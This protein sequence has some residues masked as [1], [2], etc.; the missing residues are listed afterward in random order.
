MKNP[1]SAAIAAAQESCLPLRGAAGFDN[2]PPSEIESLN[3]ANVPA[4][5]HAFSPAASKV[6]AAR[7]NNTFGLRPGAASPT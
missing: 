7:R 6:V 5:R 3:N 2:V 1:L 4:S